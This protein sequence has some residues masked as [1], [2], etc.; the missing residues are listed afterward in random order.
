VVPRSRIRTM[1]PTEACG[2]F[3]RIARTDRAGLRRE[4]PP[5]EGLCFGRLFLKHARPGGCFQLTVS[6]D[7]TTATES[8][9]V[10]RT[11]QTYHR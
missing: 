6:V 9:P 10:A 2:G 11:G 4:R 1:I 7:R 3:T 8:R 5:F